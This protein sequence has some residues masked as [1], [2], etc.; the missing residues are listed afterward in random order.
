M[1][2]ERSFQ[3]PST[4][5]ATVDA[6]ANVPLITGDS[7]GSEADHF[8]ALG[9]GP[10]SIWWQNPGAN[11]IKYRV[12]GK[13]SPTVAD[14][15]AKVVVAEATLA[16]DAEISL[17]VAVAYYSH[18]YLQHAANVAASQGASKVFGRQAA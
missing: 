6:Y 9:K 14:A 1:T 4:D 8:R 16:A 15:D 7:P 2:T 17:E 5:P 13:N 18:Y 12:L 10:L 3:T 11:T